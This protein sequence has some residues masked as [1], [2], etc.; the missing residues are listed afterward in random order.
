MTGDVNFSGKIAK[1]LNLSDI[2]VDGLSSEDKAKLDAIFNT[3]NDGDSKDA[4]TLDEIVKS[5]ANID[6]DKNGKLSDAEMKAAW[7]KLTN[8]PQGITETQYI[9]YLKAMSAANEQSAKEYRKRLYY[10]IR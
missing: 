2:K 9:S 7:Q 4:L 1:K 8:R 10:S 6:T 5:V 3:K